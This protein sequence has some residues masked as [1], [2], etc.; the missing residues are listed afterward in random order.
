[1]MC[2]DF[3]VSLDQT[4]VIKANSKGQQTILANRI[5]HFAVYTNM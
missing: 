3:E 5:G 2:N 4:Q 1:M